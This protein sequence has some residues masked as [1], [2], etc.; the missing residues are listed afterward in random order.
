VTLAGD[1]GV[2][3]NIPEHKG[4][5]DPRERVLQVGEG[6][7]VPTENDRIL[8]GDGDVRRVG[9]YE[10]VKGSAGH[11]ER[12][13]ELTASGLDSDTLARRAAWKGRAH[14]RSRQSP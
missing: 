11:E 13:L 5:N 4:V 10:A 14:R 6:V 9:P 7:K 2:C 8:E 1:H 3:D 12:K